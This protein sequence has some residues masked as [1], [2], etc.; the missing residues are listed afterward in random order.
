MGCACGC[1]KEL[2]AKK[3]PEDFVPKK[4]SELLQYSSSDDM[5]AA[6]ARPQTANGA[7]SQSQFYSV[8]QSSSSSTTAH[9][10][11]GKA[12]P[13]D[14]RPSSYYSSLQEAA[15]CP[16]TSADSFLSVLSAS[17][18]ASPTT[19]PPSSLQLARADNGSRSQNGTCCAVLSPAAD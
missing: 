10:I 2:A 15:F 3:P 19:Q 7:A 18:A 11:N 9:L 5:A 17:A 16:L 13:H 12:L 1:R 14:S 6:V 8:S 4:L